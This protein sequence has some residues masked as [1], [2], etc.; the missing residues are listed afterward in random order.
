MIG[1]QYLDLALVARGIADVVTGNEEIPEG[2]TAVLTTDTPDLVAHVAVRARNGGVL[3]ATCFE[4]ELYRQLKG[5]KDRQTLYE[6]LEGCV[7]VSR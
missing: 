6:I 4:P 2:V 7:R 5:L 1:K 3:L